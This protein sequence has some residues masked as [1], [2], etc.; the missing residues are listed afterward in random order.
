MK[1]TF[2]NRLICVFF[3]HSFMITFWFRLG[4]YFMNNK[5]IILRA[6]FP[7]VLLIYKHNEFKTGI[8][9]PLGTHVDSGF[10]FLILVV[11][12]LIVTQKLEGIA[13]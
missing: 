7:L 3:N 2:L 13:Q 1:D 10:F 12:L 5:N 8:Q 4:T 9:L 6:I 11:L